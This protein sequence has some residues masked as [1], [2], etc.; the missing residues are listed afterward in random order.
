VTGPVAIRPATPAD[1]AALA[2]LDQR[3]WSWRSS[4]APAP[5]PG[6][7]FL[8]GRV[9]PEDV[10]VAEAGGAIAGYVQIGRP[11]SV[12]AN[13]HVLMVR[14]LAVDPDRRGAGIGRA[15]VD[16]AVAEARARGA[17]RLTLHVLAPN[18]PARAV[19]VA[20]GFV[21]EGVLRDEFHL[22]GRY[23]DDVLMARDLTP[24]GEPA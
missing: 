5:P 3:T 1:D 24:D 21:V 7:P 6:T 13:A 8:D 10:L 15:L 4:P 17:R 19:Y 22:D 9:A 18:A 11:T 16:A 14:G 23:V 2:A 12:P 20:A